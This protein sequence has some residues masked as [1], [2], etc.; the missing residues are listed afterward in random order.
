MRQNSNFEQPPPDFR[1]LDPLLP[2]TM[3][4]RH[5]P[6]WRQPG[7][8][9]FV[10]FRLADSLP[11]QLVEA[12]QEE[13]SRWLE[14][15]PH[16][17]PDQWCDFQRQAFAALDDNLDGG[18]GSRILADPLVADSV[19]HAMA[20]FHGRRY[21]LCARVIMPTHVHAVVTPLPCPMTAQ[22]RSETGDLVYFELERIIGSWKQYSGKQIHAN[23]GGS[24]ALWQ[25]ELFDRIVRDTPELRRTM[26]YIENNPIKA[27]ISAP[28]WL[29]PDWT[30]WYRGV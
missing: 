4:Q 11:R 20:F 29:R 24:G 25:E 10:T 23:T 21:L 28:F 17:T 22:N 7:A 1:G 13:R 9:Y 30:K 18:Y 19:A 14:T 12:L 26:A 6:H 27:G 5:M 3:H 16:P 8:T 15:H 2:V